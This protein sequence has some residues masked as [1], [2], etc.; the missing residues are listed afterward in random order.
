MQKYFQKFD[1]YKIGKASQR[2]G[3][4]IKQPTGIHKAKTINSIKNDKFSTL[5]DNKAPSQNHQFIL[6]ICV[7]VIFSTVL[8]AVVVHDIKLRKKYPNVNNAEEQELDQDIQQFSYGTQFGDD[9][10]FLNL[11]LFNLKVHI[12]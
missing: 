6:T 11:Y 9:H 7:V 10:K 3:K 2:Q 5:L 1:E 4:D 8:I 12:F